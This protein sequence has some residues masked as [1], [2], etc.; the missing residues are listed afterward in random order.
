MFQWWLDD[1][2][3]WNPTKYE[4]VNSLSIEAHKVWKP[5]L[6]FLN[7]YVD[8]VPYVPL[9]HYILLI[10]FINDVTL[11]I[12]SQHKTKEL[13]LYCFNILYNY[14]PKLTFFLTFIIFCVINYFIRL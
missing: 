9:L 2:L 11:Q 6:V 3:S 4:G 8:Y 13:I 7:G 10:I 5:P 14:A 1:R 12:S